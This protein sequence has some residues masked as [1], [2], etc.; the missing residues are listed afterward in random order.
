MTFGHLV[1]SLATTGYIL[2]G[3]FLEERDHEYYLGEEYRQYKKRTPMILP[4]T[5]GK[6]QEPEIPP[7]FDTPGT[8]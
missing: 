1:F 7:T 6:R 8:S 2:V 4:F 3:I 5:K